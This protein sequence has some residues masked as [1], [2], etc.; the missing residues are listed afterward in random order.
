MTE[1]GAEF[2]GGPLRR[3]VD[4]VKRH[5]VVFFIV[6]F[7]T[8]GAFAIKAEEVVVWARDKVNVVANPHADEYAA[9]KT[10]DLDTRLEFFEDKFGTARSVFDLCKESVACPDMQGNTLRMFIHETD[11]VQVRAVFDGEQ[12]KMY[13]ITLMSDELSPPIEW[14]DWDMGELGKLSFAKALDA[15]ETVDEPTDAEIFLGP[16]ASAYAEVVPGGAPAQYRGLFLAHAPGGYSGL[17]S[18]FDLDSGR[19]LQEAQDLGRPP[20]P[21]TLMRFRSGSTPNTF[22]EFRDDGGAVALLLHEAG[23]LIP[24]LFLG[25]EL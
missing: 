6:T 14:L 5:S 23:D 1:P 9:L 10:L 17:K 11:D 4:R 2:R 16:Q 21:T 13:A 12:L 19:E 18:S 25:T 3:A 15:V 22:G 24:M 20:D 8:L 7:V